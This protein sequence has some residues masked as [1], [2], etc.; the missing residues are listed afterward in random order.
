MKTYLFLLLSF[1]AVTGLMA[2]QRVVTTERFMEATR[3]SKLTNPNM[4]WQN[5]FTP[6]EFYQGVIEVDS[7]I[8]SHEIR[9]AVQ[10]ALRDLQPKK[11]MTRQMHTNSTIGAIASTMDANP[12]TNVGDYYADGE[13]N[14]NGQVE[15]VDDILYVRFIDGIK[16]IRFYTDYK[17][18]FREGRYRIT[19][20]P[21]GNSGYAVNTIQVPWEQMYRRGEL[22]GSYNK[23]HSWMSMELEQTTA[24]LI[25]MIEEY[26]SPSDEADSDW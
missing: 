7:S 10:Q 22:K 16:L 23:G 14:E 15:R 21:V 8:N 12:S 9:L 6:E 1:S 3:A 11:L 24:E 2:Q 4:K 20:T 13:G 25:L 18:E 5:L 19:A 17:F 26:L